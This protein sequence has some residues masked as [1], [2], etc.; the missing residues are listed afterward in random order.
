MEVETVDVLVVDDQAPFRAVARTL[1]GLTPGLQFV[2]EACSGE[3]A[4]EVARSLRPPLVLM[5]INLPGISGIEATRQL[6]AADPSVTVILMSTYAAVDLPADAMESGAAGY[7]RKED[8]TPAAL[9]A[10]LPG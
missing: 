5:D 8:L 6:R 1:V 10:L 2:A 3:E 4:V 9:A 7:L